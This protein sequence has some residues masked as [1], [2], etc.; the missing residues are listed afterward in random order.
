MLFGIELLEIVIKNVYIVIWK[1]FIHIG[2]IQLNI[3]SQ[4]AN[5]QRTSILLGREV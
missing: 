4:M 2:S 1:L 5:F 3:V